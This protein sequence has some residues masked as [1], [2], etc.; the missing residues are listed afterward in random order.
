MNEKYVKE[1]IIRLVNRND[2]SITGV[3]KV[4]SFSPTQ[5]ALVAMDCEIEICGEQLQTTKLDEQSGDLF[6]QG[7]IKNIKWIEKKEKVGFIKRIFK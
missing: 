7:L 5:I 6:V 4:I 1:N 3:S 2:L